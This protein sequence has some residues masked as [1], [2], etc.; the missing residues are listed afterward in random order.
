M[1]F[2][3]LES[4]ALSRR[5]GCRSVLSLTFAFGRRSNAMAQNVP[6]EL[7]TSINRQVLDHLEGLSAHSD[8][9]EALTAALRPLGDVQIFCPDCQQYRYVVGSTKGIIIAL[10][11]GM[12]TTGFRLDERMKA[13][14]LASGGAPLPECGPGW[15][16]F[17]LFRDDWPRI[18]LEFWA[19]KAYV[20]ARELEG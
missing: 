13:R 14:A 6:P 16:A 5:G 8:V 1:C 10:A 20:A 17:T 4:R 3:C 7:K 15:V 18:D 9:A 11:V 12:N 19:R 2:G